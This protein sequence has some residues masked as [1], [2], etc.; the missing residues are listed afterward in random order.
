M[1]K[2]V[3]I[4]GG[5]ALPDGQAPDPKII[6]DVEDLLQLAK[7]GM[8]TGFVAIAERRDGLHTVYQEGPFGIEQMIGHMH[9]QLFRMTSEAE[10]QDPGN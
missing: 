7:D 8:I 10:R 5:V 6:K 1:S 4:V 3:S 9:R 2:I